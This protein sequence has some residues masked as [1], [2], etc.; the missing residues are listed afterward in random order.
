MF[1]PDLVVRSRRVVAR[2]G[3]RPAAVHIRRGKII[4]V[5]DFD[6]VPA[7]SPLDD[8]GAAMLIPGLVDTHVHVGGSG[9]T[10]P[11]A[12]DAV[13]RAAAAGGVTTLIDTSVDGGRVAGSVASLEERRRSAEGHCFVDVGF[14]GAIVPGNAKELAPLLATGVL[15]LTCSLSACDEDAAVAE[16]D[17]RLA[18]PLLTSLGAPL[19]AHAELQALIDAAT[20]RSRDARGW[21]ARLFRT[22]T[23][24]RRYAHYL[25]TRPKEAE[26][27]A[28]A[29]LIDLCRAYRTRTHIARLSSSD[30]LAP[31][32]R[33]RSAGLSISA[34]TCPHYLYFIA[35]DIPDGATQF[36]CIPPIRERD[37]RELLWAALAGGVI[38]MI[39]SDHRP[40]SPAPE[41]NDFMRA[42]AGIWSLQ[43]SLAA[44]WTVAYPRGST[45]NHV[46][47][48]MCREPARLAGLTRKGAIDVGYDADLVVWDP[49]VEFTV[50][51]AALHDRN[52]KT[53]Y[54]GRRLRGVVSRTYLRGTLICEGGKVL[55]PPRGRLLAAPRRE[56]PRPPHLRL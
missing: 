20:E 47:R 44:M 36:K 26:N 51:P 37:N 24:R 54:A 19:V 3:V 8:A 32:F 12:F 6:N 39:S 40:R 56:G 35:D 27:E 16:T 13:T 21:M 38:Q 17:L 28:I 5:L 14:W 2:D 55:P 33:A 11:E 15:G 52:A 45:P 48:W 30:A 53:P 31:L 1:F 43:L 34:A 50:D 18:M 22:R 49:D 25:A 29:R 9:R 42:A 41:T 4:G 10:A 23:G 7:G 46:A